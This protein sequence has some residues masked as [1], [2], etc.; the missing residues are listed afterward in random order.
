V[1]KLFIDIG[2]THL[3]SEICEG[4]EVISAILS[5]NEI[6]LLEY[7]DSVVQLHPQIGFIGISY[8]GQ[9]NS[10]TILSAPNIHI[11]EYDIASLVHQKYGIPLKIDNDLNC[12]VR[13]E[14][15]YWGEETL[16]AVY[17]GTGIGAAVMDHG[18][19][20]RGGS[21]LAFELG[22]IP[23]KTSP[24]RC[25][26]GRNNCLEL[27]VSGSGM[28]KWME[29]YQLD[30]LSNLATL[31]NGSDEKALAVVHAFEE[32]FLYA[33]GIMV[34]LANP[35]LLVLGGGVIQQN[36]YLVTLLSEK[37]ADYALEGSLRDL[38]IEMSALENAPL[39]GAKL[40]EQ[41]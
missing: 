1:K 37:L 13:A 2:G 3:R 29:Y 25:G 23:Y 28:L 38:R 7:I 41:G 21:N 5:S 8:A 24:I 26:C 16:A 14:A 4:D 18:V 39:E 31:K 34:T 33:I 11:D 6:G 32:A 12:A 20:V 35:K 19:V 36:P 10:G 15:A 17:V 30:L 9:V 40:L 27:Y 22:H